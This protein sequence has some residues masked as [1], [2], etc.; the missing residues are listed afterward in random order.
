[1][2]LE[3]IGAGFGRNA[4]N[5]LRR[6]LEELGFGPCHHMFEIS[7]NE[8]LLPEWE[9]IVK[10]ESRNWDAAFAGYRSQVDW[11]GATYWRELAEYY[12]DAKI[13]LSVRPVEGWYASF[14]KTIVPYIENRGK[15]DT[16]YRNRQSEMVHELI[17][18]QTFG[19]RLRDRD[20]VMSIY[21][22]H[23]AEVQASVPPDKLLT[24]EVGTGWEPLCAFLGVEVPDTEYPNTNSTKDFQ[25]RT[26]SNQENS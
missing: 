17:G 5:S 8:G 4:T 19:D 11:P 3:V 9:A 16:P 12:P 7:E 15:H 23:T 1:M 18:R 13:V 10:G 22:A 2:A 14:E 20:Y 24:Y 21:E 26:S 25:K 6:A